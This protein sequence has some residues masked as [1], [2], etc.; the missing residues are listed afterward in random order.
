MKITFYMKL[1]FVYAVIVSE[2]SISVLMKMNSTSM[3]GIIQSHYVHP[4]KNL[5]ML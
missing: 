3:D 2:I 5:T 4:G 1:L